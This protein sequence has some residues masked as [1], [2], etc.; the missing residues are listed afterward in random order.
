MTVR[1]FSQWITSITIKLW[2]FLCKFL[3]F[4]CSRALLF[5]VYLPELLQQWRTGFLLKRCGSNSELF[6]LRKRILKRPLKSGLFLYAKYREEC[7]LKSRTLKTDDT[8]EL[9]AQK[10]KLPQIWGN[11]YEKQNPKPK[12]HQSYHSV[13]VL[14]EF[15]LVWVSVK[16]IY[17]KESY[18]GP[19]ASWRQLSCAYKM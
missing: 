8:I 2:L 18:S 10:L 15:S 14:C 5:W 17:L 4:S 13:S 1:N 12:Q 9:N 3:M 16:S 6:G 11:M 7:V 19:Q